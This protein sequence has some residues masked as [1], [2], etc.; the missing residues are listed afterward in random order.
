MKCSLGISN[1]LEEI[2]S[3]SHSIVFLYF[4][5]LITEE[6][7]VISPCYS[8]ELC[9]QMCISSFSPFPFVSLLFIVICKAYSDNHFAFLHFFQ[10]LKDDVMKVLN[11]ICQRIW[12]ARQ[13]TQDCKSSV[14]IPIPKKGNAKDCS[15]YC[16][17]AVI[18]HASKVMLKILQP[19]LQ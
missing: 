9:I 10:I 17:V 13:W 6:V 19:R 4:F 12:K 14:F 15:N 3:H 18:S 2:S 16:A 5:T 11:S 8:L 1:S 7:F